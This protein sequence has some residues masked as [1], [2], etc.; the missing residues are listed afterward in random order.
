LFTTLQAL[1][2]ETETQYISRQP[3]HVPAATNTSD[4]LAMALLS[5]KKNIVALIKTA[6][7]EC[8]EQ[9]RVIKLPGRGACWAQAP[10][11]SPLPSAT[12]YCPTSHISPFAGPLLTFVCHFEPLKLWHRPG[13]PKAAVSKLENSQI[14]M[15]QAHQLEAAQRY[16]PV[17]TSC[18]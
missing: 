12:T 4:S 17:P 1:A 2:T 15:Y 7:D 14:Q 10:M 5:D 8:I 18:C 3:G 13:G 16:Q 9:Q 11:A 6:V